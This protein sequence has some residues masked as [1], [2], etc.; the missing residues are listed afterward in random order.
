MKKRI[1]LPLKIAFLVV[2]AQLLGCHKFIDIKDIWH[3]HNPGCR[4]E[5]ISFFLSGGT[6]PVSA[7]FYYNNKGNPVRVSS[8]DGM[9]PPD[10]YFYYDEKDRLTDYLGTFPND[11]YFFWYHY[12]YD[13]KGRVIADTLNGFGAI[14][15]ASRFPMTS[16]NGIRCMNTILLTG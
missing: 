5:K 1:A 4:I 6:E 13:N 12:M 11:T 10:N 8:P 2:F 3:Q 9:Y 16:S 15:M 14:S 7:S